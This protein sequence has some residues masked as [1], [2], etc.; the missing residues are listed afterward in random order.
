MCLVVWLYTVAALNFLSILLEEFSFWYLSVRSWTPQ[1][2]ATSQK[3]TCDNEARTGKPTSPTPSCFSA[4]LFYP[5]L[6]SVLD[7]F[8]FRRFTQLSFWSLFLDISKLYKT[9]PE[10]KFSAPGSPASKK[11]N[12]RF[13]ASTSTKAHRWNPVISSLWAWCIHFH[14]EQHIFY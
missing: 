7:E 11:L 3:T 13:S 6:A 2:C 14:Q 10:L 4:H 5:Y 8:T 9:W 12:F 1:T